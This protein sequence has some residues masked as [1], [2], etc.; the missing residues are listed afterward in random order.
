[1]SGKKYGPTQQEQ[2]SSPHVKTIKATRQRLNRANSELV[3]LK[4]DIPRAH[5]EQRRA[6]SAYQASINKLQRMIERQTLLLESAESYEADI[7]EMERIIEEN[8]SKKKKR[9]RKRS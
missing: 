1:M 9:R 4:Y 5:T 7:K 3:T 8:K 6:E 2:R